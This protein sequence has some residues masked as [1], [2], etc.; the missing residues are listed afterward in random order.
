[1]PAASWMMSLVASPFAKS[2]RYLDLEVGVGRG[3]SIHEM[4][5]GQDDRGRDEGAGAPVQVLT[6]GVVE[7]E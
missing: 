3:G 1:M 2:S 4:C 6:F 7:G 5:R